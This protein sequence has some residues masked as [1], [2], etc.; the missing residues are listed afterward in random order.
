[1]TER[2]LFLEKINQQAVGTSIQPSLLNINLTV[3]P[4]TVDIWLQHFARLAAL[5]GCWLEHYIE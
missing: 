2:V 3:L 4:T 1:M 5:T